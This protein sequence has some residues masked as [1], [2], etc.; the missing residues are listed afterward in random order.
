MENRI[1]LKNLICTHNY[2]IE[3]ANSINIYAADV[4]KLLSNASNLCTTNTR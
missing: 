1:Y 3:R 2:V 4:E